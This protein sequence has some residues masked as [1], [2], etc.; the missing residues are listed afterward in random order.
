[1]TYGTIT[2]SGIRHVYDKRKHFF[3]SKRSMESRVS[4]KKNY[5]IKFLFQI[6]VTF[7]FISNAVLHNQSLMILFK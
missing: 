4:C 3:Q 1:M 2:I 7:E 5:L 6:L